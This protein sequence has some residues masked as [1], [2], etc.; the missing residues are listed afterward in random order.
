MVEEA[1]HRIFHKVLAVIA[2][3]GLHWSSIMFPISISYPHHVVSL[4]SAG[5]LRIPPTCGL[6][7]LV[8]VSCLLIN[9]FSVV[10]IFQLLKRWKLRARWFYSGSIG[11]IIT[12]FFCLFSGAIW[13]VFIMV[14]IWK[15]FRSRRAQF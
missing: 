12:M 15:G 5:L 7:L 2:I 8:T 1:G 14:A 4:S 6:G 9:V 11:T 10:M 3:A 13:N